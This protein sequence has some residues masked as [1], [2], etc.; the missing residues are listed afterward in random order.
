MLGTLVIFHEI[1]YLELYSTL[2]FCK[3]ILLGPQQFILLDAIQLTLRF[4]Q[5]I[6]PLIQLLL[7]TAYTSNILA[8]NMYTIWKRVF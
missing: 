1:K 3:Y 8:N 4:D 6:I 7:N 2:L 5:H